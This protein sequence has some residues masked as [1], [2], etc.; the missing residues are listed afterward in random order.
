MPDVRLDTNVVH[1]HSP[2]YTH[3]QTDF[4]AAAAASMCRLHV[5]VTA[6]MTQTRVQNS[7]ETSVI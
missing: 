6:I 1:A 7:H 4:G 3:M 2:C 5:R